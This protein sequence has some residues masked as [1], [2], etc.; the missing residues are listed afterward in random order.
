MLTNV[1]ETLNKYSLKELGEHFGVSAPSISKR[2]K[3]I[4]ETMKQLAE[5]MVAVTH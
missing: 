5:E 2:S 1:Y 4:Q 3:E